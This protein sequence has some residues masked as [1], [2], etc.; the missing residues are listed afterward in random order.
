MNAR[1]CL[2]MTCLLLSACQTQRE[3]FTSIWSPAEV[4]EDASA[5]PADYNQLLD[6]PLGQTVDNSAVVNDPNK[7]LTLTDIS[8]NRE[9]LILDRISQERGILTAMIEFRYVKPQTLPANGMTYH[10]NQWREQIDCKNKV[11]I[12]RNTTHYNMAGEIVD[13]IDYP[14]PKY[15]PAELAA[16]SQPDDKVI[17]YVCERA[18]AAGLAVGDATVASTTDGKTKTTDKAADKTKATN[19]K[20]DQKGKTK[21]D[22]GVKV[23]EK[24][25]FISKGKAESASAPAAPTDTSAPAVEKTDDAP[26]AKPTDTNDKDKKAAKKSSKKDKKGKK[27]QKDPSSDKAKPDTQ[28]D[29]QNAETPLETNA[30]AGND[31][32]EVL[33]GEVQLKPI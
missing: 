16:L 30:P 32:V 19:S 25:D 26:A 12:L 7:L 29:K 33:E 18:G 4:V 9:Y 27:D 31:D 5:H 21:A 2:I 3:K 10:Y 13:T 1:L 11:R 23:D 6:N 24:I 8:G 20:K 17:Q 15:K 28:S 14:L 22:A